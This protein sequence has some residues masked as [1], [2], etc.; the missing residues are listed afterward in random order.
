MLTSPF[1][2]A[3]EHLPKAKQHQHHLPAPNIIPILWQPPAQVFQQPPPTP[4]IKLWDFASPLHTLLWVCILQYCGLAVLV[5]SWLRMDV[6]SMVPVLMLALLHCCCR[7]HFSKG[8]HCSPFTAQW[9]SEQNYMPH[10]VPEWVPLVR[11]WGA[12]RCTYV[13]G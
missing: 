13:C 12:P 2:P 1:G 11:G 6:E 4:S 9:L 5:S 7:S 3:R 10:G 8:F